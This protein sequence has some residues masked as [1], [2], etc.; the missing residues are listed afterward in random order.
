VGSIGVLINGFGF[1][2]TM[3]KLGVERRLLTAGEHKGLFDPFSPVEEGEVEH[4]ETI[5]EDLH[6]Q[7]IEQVRE[8]RGDRL[9]DGEEL[10]SGLVWSGERSV[11][12]GLADGFGSASSVAREIVEAEKL[13]DFTRRGDL[14]ERLAERLGA[15]VGTALARMLGPQAALRP[16]F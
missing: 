5:L 7:F 13:V 9:A 11:E 16:W 3:D 15:G 4:L 1:T 12:L 6:A 2:G 14:M 10:F 8:G